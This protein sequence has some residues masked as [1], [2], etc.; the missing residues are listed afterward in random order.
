MNTRQAMV[1]IKWNN[2]IVHAVLLWDMNWITQI[3]CNVCFRV[4]QRLVVLRVHLVHDNK[5]LNLLLK[6]T[7]KVV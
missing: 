7:N 5:V 4:L 6:Y 3:S 2:D 1:V